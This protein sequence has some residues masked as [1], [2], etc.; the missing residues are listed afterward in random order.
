[1]RGEH[2]IIN[3]LKQG[4]QAARQSLVTLSTSYSYAQTYNVGVVGL[5]FLRRPD[6]LLGLLEVSNLEVAVRDVALERKATSP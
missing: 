3:G 6:V 4:Q 2:G 5:L 1:M